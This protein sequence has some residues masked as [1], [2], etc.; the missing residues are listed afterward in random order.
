MINKK[1]INLLF[2]ILITCF[3]FYIPIINAQGNKTDLEEEY[4]NKWNEKSWL[5]LGDS[6]TKANGY[7]IIVKEKLGFSNVDNKG[8]NGQT[9][10]YQKNDKSTYSIGKNINY[11]KYDLVTIFIGTNDFR[12]NKKLGNIKENNYDETTFIGSYQMLIERILSSNPEVELVLITP[13]QR[14]KDGYDINYINK[15]GNKLVDY[16]NSI[17]ALGEK[18]SLPVL[19]LYSTSG[20]TSDTMDIYTRDDLHPNKRGF[21]RIS[22]KMYRFLLNI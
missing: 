8:I 10:A 21:E 19:D 14:T 12:Y 5:T 22:E 13:L 9:M 1:R 15:A 7:Q 6:I 2:F 3:I 4:F 17:K 18:Y 11:K 20:F 16:V